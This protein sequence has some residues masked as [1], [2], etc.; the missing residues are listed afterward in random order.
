MRRASGAALLVACARAEDPQFAGLHRALAALSA[1]GAARVLRW[2]GGPLAFRGGEAPAAL[3]LAGHGREDLPGVGDGDGCGLG[4][5]GL[6]CPSRTRLYLLACGQG[7]DE[8]RAGWARGTGLS[9]S[10][11]RG[12]EGETETLLSTLF[13]LHLARA[14][15]AGLDALFDQWVLANRIVRP[16]FPAARALYRAAGGDPL[17][18][19]SY[20]ERAADLEPVRGFL[21]LAPSC[22]E[23]LA[24]ILPAG[25]WL[26]RKKRQP[27]AGLPVCRCLSTGL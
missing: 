12:A 2:D 4:P 13:V 24:G 14:G 1:S 17:L 7:R 9:P 18:V 5:Q 22:V 6:R 15:P 26:P 20:L 11:V 23:Y 25:E 27:P 10:R 21:A 16:F 8:L 19:L 3:L